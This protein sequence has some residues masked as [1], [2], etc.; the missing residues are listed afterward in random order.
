MTLVE[1]PYKVLDNFCHNQPL[2]IMSMSSYLLHSRIDNNQFMFNLLGFSPT[3][4][5]RPSIDRLDS[6]E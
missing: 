4:V 1:N 5:N 2:G 6:S 3:T